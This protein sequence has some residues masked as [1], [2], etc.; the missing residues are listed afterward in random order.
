M[1]SRWVLLG[2]ALIGAACT[3]SIIDPGGNENGNGGPGGSVKTASGELVA[4]SGLRRLTAAEYDATVKDLLGETQAASAMLLPT[5][6]RTPFDNDY[7]FQ[8]PS[9]ALIEGA[10]LLAAQTADRLI[11]DQARRD[12]I[13]G[14]SPSGPDDAVCFRTFVT[15]FGKRA[16]RRPLSTDEIDRFVALQSLAV[17]ANDFWIGV[18]AAVRAFL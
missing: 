17:E 2:V 11:G 5:D 3:G 1:W 7:K 13:V 9:Q 16:L 15:S 18:D 14:C 8:V 10:E 12:Q 6:P 4:V